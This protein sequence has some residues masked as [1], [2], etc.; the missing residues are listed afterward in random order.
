[1]NSGNIETSPSSGGGSR[2]TPADTRPS[3][4]GCCENE[5]KI[6]DYCRHSCHQS[7]HE[8]IQ[9]GAKDF[10]E[11]FLPVMKE[12]AEEETH[13]EGDSLNDYLMVWHNAEEGINV[14]SE[15]Y[16]EFVEGL[17]KLIASAEAKGREEGYIDGQKHAFGVDR[18]R[19]K[20]EGAAEERERI[21][22]LIEGQKIICL[23]Q[24][25]LGDKLPYCQHECP[26]N[27]LIDDLLSRLSGGQPEN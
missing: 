4:D 16:D 25:Q 1:M 20:A 12:L 2:P 27:S 21:A 6:G 7:L 13:S 15:D 8:K 19:V 11:R 24:H 9:R 14:F 22:K 18:G 23:E 10:A 3:I 26:T 17:E 5:G